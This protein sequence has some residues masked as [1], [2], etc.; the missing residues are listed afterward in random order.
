M[1]DGTET[2]LGLEGRVALV[3]GGTR[4]LGLAIARKLCSAGCDVV[5]N[6]AGSD[7]A[8][9]AALDS[10]AGLKGAASLAR[11]DI[12]EPQTVPR[13]LEEAAGRHG[14][15]DILV[16]NAAS[17]QPM[18]ALRPD[19]AALRRDLSTAVDPLLYGATAFADVL[20]ARGRGRIVAV[21]S[22]GARN[23]VPGYVSLGLA[24]AA[25]ESLV[26]YLAVELAGRGVAVNAVATHKLDK[27][28]PDGRPEVAAMLAARTPAGRL[29]RPADVADVVALL[30]TDEAA[31]IHGQ[32]IGVDGG[33][34]LHA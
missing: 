29:T 12:R 25:L 16:H 34:S 23:V 17:W 14:G 33:L 9:Q 7:E 11:G 13:L 27:G 1:H 6:Y 19:Q 24:K 4:G 28:V 30:C 22:T 8:A 31:W 20:G 32:V 15:L 10:L 21:S 18:P 26:R 3:T 5:L 2:T